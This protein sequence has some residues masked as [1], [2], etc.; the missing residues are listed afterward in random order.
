MPRGSENPRENCNW[1]FLNSS[2]KSPKWNAGR[3]KSSV[4]VYL[5]RLVK[6]GEKKLKRKRGSAIHVYYQKE[7]LL[8]KKKSN[9][10]KEEEKNLSHRGEVPDNR[11]EK[12]LKR[13]TPRIQTERNL[14]GAGSRGKA[15][16]PD[17]CRAPENKAPLSWKK[18]GVRQG[19]G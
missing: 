4:R 5:I 2:A 1:H 6:R 10:R 13:P 8:S 11:K 14:F 19:A 12:S 16:Q 18:N 17:N 15:G 7:V 9:G 3:Q